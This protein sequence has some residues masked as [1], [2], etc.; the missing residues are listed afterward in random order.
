MNALDWY[1]IELFESEKSLADIIVQLP[2]DYCHIAAFVV[3]GMQ[4]FNI[5]CSLMA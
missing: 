2:K 5:A 4:Q 1:V 3:R